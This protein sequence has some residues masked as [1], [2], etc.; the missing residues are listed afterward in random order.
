MQ[1]KNCVP[2]L[3][4]YRL[5]EVIWIT[6]S[7][8]F[9]WQPISSLST[10]CHMVTCGF[11][12]RPYFLCPKIEEGTACGP[13]DCSGDIYSTWLSCLWSADICLHWLNTLLC[14][15]TDCLAFTDPLQPFTGYLLVYVMGSHWRMQFFLW[16]TGCNLNDDSQ[17]WSLT[18]IMP[19][20]EIWSS[21][22]LHFL[23]MLPLEGCSKS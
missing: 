6:L 1:L 15:C 21:P 9:C 11:A 18:I 7:L 22:H 16:N 8:L 23:R 4:K 20:W 17:T 19:S 12:Y 3:Q 14:A 13:R 5:L 2:S 10:D